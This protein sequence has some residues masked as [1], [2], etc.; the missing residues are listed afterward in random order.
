[1]D[2]CSLSERVLGEKEPPPSNYGGSAYTVGG[3]LSK[4]GELSFDEEGQSSSL[5]AAPGSMLLDWLRCTL[6]DKP[7]TWVFLREY[8]GAMT[9]REGGWRWYDRSWAALESG[10]VAACSDPVKAAKQGVHV[11]LPG[12][13]CALFGDDLELF[14][15]QCTERG[16]IGRADFAADDR[17]GLLTRDRILAAFAS[18]GVVSTWRDSPSETHKLSHDSSAGWTFYFG[19][20]N[21][22]AMIRIYDKAAEQG[23]SGPWVRLELEAHHGVADE[24]CRR[25]FDESRPLAEQGSTVVI[26]EIN[27]RLRFAM[28][29]MS[30]SNRWRWPAS[31]WWAE[32]LGS[33]KRGAPLLVGVKPE[34]TVQRIERYLFNQVAPSL[35]TVLQYHQRD[36]SFDL[37]LELEKSGRE[38]Q[39]SRQLAALEAAKL[40]EARRWKAVGC[41]SLPA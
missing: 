11:A 35:A 5:A 6:P 34:L 41:A 19:S 22:D 2:Q 15:L 17:S 33:L 28:P 38:R 29:V 32:F 16:K 30:D 20:R 10:F 37:V 40:P 7:D 36:S 23:V 21:G 18:G 4:E 31:P 12:R 14:W 1:M 39:N 9:E 3:L 25:W 13:A 24:L 26:E 8:L 27:R